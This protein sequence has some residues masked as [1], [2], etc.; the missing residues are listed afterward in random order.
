MLKFYYL[1]FSVDFKEGTQ[2]NEIIPVKPDTSGVFN[3]LINVEDMQGLDKE[4]N[5]LKENWRRRSLLATTDVPMNQSVR[6]TSH[7]ISHHVPATR[8]AF[9]VMTMA[10][11]LKVQD[12]L[13]DKPKEVQ[14]AVLQLQ[15]LKSF[16]SP[17][18][19]ERFNFFIVSPHWC[20]SSREYRTLLEAY[21]K[22]YPDSELYLH[23][24]VVEDPKEEIFD[25][26]VFRDLFPFPGKY[27]HESVPRFIAMEVVE[28]GAK[29]YEE[30]EA[31]EILYERLS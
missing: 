5:S 6:I 26:N 8:S 31:L 17:M 16:I 23:S 2:P 10:E 20:D 3:R 11:R 18:E 24:I 19:L 21:L 27:S 29:I 9:D 1:P 12:I 30:G 28:S 25:S 4:W 22:E 7:L 14:K 13:K 15:F